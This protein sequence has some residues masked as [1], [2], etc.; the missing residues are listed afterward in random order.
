MKI[1]LVSFVSFL[2]AI[3]ACSP[4][5]PEPSDFGLYENGEHLVATFTGF[6]D[7]LEACQLAAKTFREESHSDPAAWAAINKKPDD[8]VCAKLR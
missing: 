4:K 8:W 6:I 3:A 2:L 5:Q 7:N 1:K